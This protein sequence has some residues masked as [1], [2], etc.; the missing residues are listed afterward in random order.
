MPPKKV[1][2]WSL[3]PSLHDGVS[4]LLEEVDLDYEFYGI[5][6]PAT[7]KIEHDTTIMGKFRCYNKNCPSK[8]W[9]SRTIAITIRLYDGQ[10][11]NAR[12]YFQRCESCNRLSKPTLDNSYAERIA[13]RIKRWNSVEV[14]EP[15]F[16]G[17]MEK[18]PHQSDLCEGCKAGHCMI[19][20]VH[21]R[22]MQCM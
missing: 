21:R 18:G 13:Y 1:R 7:S 11:Y 22:G 15:H 12:V 4:N 5:D 8:G 16:S 9:G 19:S 10:K 6:D 20:S 14:E 17:R 3:Y 2:S